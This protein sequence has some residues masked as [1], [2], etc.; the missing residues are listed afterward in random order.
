MISE[1]RGEGRPLID[2]LGSRNVNMFIGV[3]YLVLWWWGL[4]TFV[5]IPAFVNTAWPIAHSVAYAVAAAVVHFGFMAIG[6]VLI[7][8]Y[9]P[10]PVSPMLLYLAADVVMLFSLVGI[11]ASYIR[12]EFA[13]TVPLV[14]TWLVMMALALHLWKLYE[15]VFPTVSKE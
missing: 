8:D 4:G 7:P 11:V 13:S 5:L 12:S 9:V 15:L 3:L 1:Y 14:G 6:A 10:Y 2:R